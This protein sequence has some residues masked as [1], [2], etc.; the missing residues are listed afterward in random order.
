MLIDSVLRNLTSSVLTKEEIMNWSIVPTKWYERQKLKITKLEPIIILQKGNL[1]YLISGFT[2]LK[3]TQP[4]TTLPAFYVRI[5]N[6]ADAIRYI[7]TQLGVFYLRNDIMEIRKELKLLTLEEHL[8]YMT[9]EFYKESTLEDYLKQHYD[10][11][12]GKSVRKVDGQKLGELYYTMRLRDNFKTVWWDALKLDGRDMH[13]N[14]YVDA[15]QDSES[16]NEEME[17]L[18]IP[19]WLKYLRS[20]YIILSQ[21]YAQREVMPF[22]VQ[23]ARF[24]TLIMPKVMLRYVDILKETKL[25]DKTRLEALKHVLFTPTYVIDDN[26]LEKALEPFYEVFTS[27]FFVGE[28]PKVI[29]HVETLA[30]EL[31]ESKLGD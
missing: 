1:Q 6:M 11:V 14:N 3:H 23:I 10:L 22:T 4:Y 24:L 13:V 28:S 9:Q 20:S 16:T 2:L 15:I 8:L 17:Q 30:Y 18:H 26:L 29:A 21:R 25:S 7:E 31:M 19:M 12:K 27:T 5:D